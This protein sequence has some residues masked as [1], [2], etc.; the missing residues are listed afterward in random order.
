MPVGLTD[1]AEAQVSRPVL[2]HE[3]IGIPEEEEV[4]DGV[5]E[6]AGN[7]PEGD[8]GGDAN[9]DPNEREGCPHA[10]AQKVLQDESDEAHRAQS[11]DADSRRPRLPEGPEMAATRA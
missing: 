7:D 3:E 5:L 11:L 9:A 2:G 6:T 1:S 8:H 4:S 10:L